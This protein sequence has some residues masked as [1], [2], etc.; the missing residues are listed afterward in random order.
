MHAGWD[1]AS[2]RGT[3]QCGRHAGQ[4]TGGCVLKWCVLR[5]CGLLIVARCNALHTLAKLQVSLH[6]IT[7]LAG[8]NLPAWP[9]LKG[10]K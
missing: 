4:A 7:V 8:C 1:G 6:A 3:V 10:E 9:Q 2:R 5:S